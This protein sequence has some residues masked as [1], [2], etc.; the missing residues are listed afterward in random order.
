MSIRHNFLGIW[1]LE[2]MKILSKRPIKG[3]MYG[4]RLSIFFWVG[5]AGYVTTI[6]EA[7]RFVE[8]TRSVSLSPVWIVPETPRMSWR[9]ML[10]TQ[11][12]IM[13]IVEARLMTGRLLLMAGW[14]MHE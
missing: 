5:M 7:R 3:G 6:V 8:V 14:D 12:G 10:R 11:N 1:R 9:G 13:T 2:N 4:G